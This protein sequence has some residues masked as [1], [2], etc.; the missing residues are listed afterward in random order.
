MSKTVVP[1]LPLPMALLQPHKTPHN[2]LVC[3]HVSNGELESF[4]K[5]MVD[6]SLWNEN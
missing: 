6:L 3:L 5:L 4:G 2:C 1:M